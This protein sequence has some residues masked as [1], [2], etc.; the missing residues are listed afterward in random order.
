[1][2]RGNSSGPLADHKSG[3]NQKRVK[4]KLGIS[5]S[6]SFLAIM[7]YGVITK[8]GVNTCRA[9][10][11][12]YVTCNSPRT[13]F[14]EIGKFNQHSAQSSCNCV[15]QNTLPTLL[16]PPPSGLIYKSQCQNLSR[17]F[18]FMVEHLNLFVPAHTHTHSQSEVD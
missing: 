5:R 14:T 4:L 3:V 6:L 7:G 2:G 15:T 9:E 1:M 18:I 17:K 10:R 8:T 11:Q 12:E 16:T 13:Q